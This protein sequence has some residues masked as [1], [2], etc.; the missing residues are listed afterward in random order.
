MYSYNLSAGFPI[1]SYPYLSAYSCQ[2]ELHR[3]QCYVISEDNTM[4]RW[5][6]IA[7]DQWHVQHTLHFSGFNPLPP[8]LTHTRWARSHL[9]VLPTYFRHFTN[10]ALSVGNDFLCTFST[11]HLLNTT[12]FLSPR[13]TCTQ[14]MQ[15]IC[16]RLSWSERH[17]C[18][19]VQFATLYN[20]SF[21]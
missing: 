17:T 11:S 8:L 16:H 10:D 7:L 18:L 12:I 9:L 6:H 5:L 15:A 4:P 21:I 3:M 20:Y 2:A 14:I 1:I 19:L 13:E